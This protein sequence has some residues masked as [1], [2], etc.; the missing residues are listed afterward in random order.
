MSEI[1]YEV[2]MVLGHVDEENA[3]RQT[4]Q[5]FGTLNEM[6]EG[7]RQ[8]ARAEKLEMEAQIQKALADAA[9]EEREKERKKMQRYACE[10]S[11]RKWAAIK[12]C[13]KI[14]MAVAA[15][16]GFESLM[17]LPH[18]LTLASMII[19]L[20]LALRIFAVQVIPEVLWY[21]RHKAVMVR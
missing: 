20:L 6:T 3:E 11:R 15:L 10:R 21:L 8:Q 18:E 16:F 19:L 5:M 2:E 4:V 13:G 14:L 1:E 7:Y 17:G 12:R 9:K